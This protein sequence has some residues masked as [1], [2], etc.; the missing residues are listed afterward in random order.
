MIKNEIK[1]R[2]FDHRIKDYTEESFDTDVDEENVSE[3]TDQYVVN[4][5]YSM[6][7]DGDL[8]TFELFTGVFDND[9]QEM[10]VGDI[11]KCPKGRNDVIE[12]KFGAFW[13][14]YRNITLYKFL[15]ELNAKV[16]VIGNILKTPE[17]AKV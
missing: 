9:G 14:R 13:L 15:F 4:T 5:M 2:A 8:F 7:P 10:F 11:L 12:M 16:E 3:T 1:F 17:L 6:G